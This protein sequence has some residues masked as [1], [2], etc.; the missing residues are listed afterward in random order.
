MT[1][2]FGPSGPVRMPPFPCLTAFE[3][4]LAGKLPVFRVCSFLDTPRKTPSGNVLE[5]EHLPHLVAP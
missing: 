2:V 3:E 4:G 5:I 1:K